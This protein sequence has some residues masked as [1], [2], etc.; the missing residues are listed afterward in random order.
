MIGVAISH[1]RILSKL[2]AGEMGEVYLA[3]DGSEYIKAGDVVEGSVPT[4]LV[5]MNAKASNGYSY[6]VAG[7]GRRFLIN[8]LVEGNKPAPITVVLNWTSDLKRQR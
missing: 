7:D 6:A 1:Y 5:P 2:G 4:A 8:R 3:P